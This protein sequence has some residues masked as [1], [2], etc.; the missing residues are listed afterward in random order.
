MCLIFWLSQRAST[1]LHAVVKELFLQ[2]RQQLGRDTKNEG[3]NYASVC[4]SELLVDQGFGKHLRE[5][6]ARSRVY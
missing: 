5:D 6:S 1:T 2:S 4:A 3:I